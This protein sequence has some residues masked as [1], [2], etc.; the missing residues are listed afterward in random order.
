ME[1]EHVQT[2]I[3]KFVKS[4]WEFEITGWKTPAP[5]ANVLAN[6][7]GYGVL[8]TADSVCYSWH[9]DSKKR[10]INRWV[11]DFS[12]A[13]TGR[14]F[15]IGFNDTLVSIPW[16][17]VCFNWESYKCFHA[18]G[19]TRWEACAGPLSVTVTVFVPVNVDA[20]IWLWEFSSEIPLDI[21]FTS[22]CELLLG[23]EWETHREFY[24]LRARSSLN[25]DIL[26]ISRENFEVFF[27]QSMAKK[28]TSDL[29][30]FM[31]RAGS[32]RCP[33]GAFKG[34]FGNLIDPAAAIRS[35]FRVNEPVKIVFSMGVTPDVKFTPEDAERLFEETKNFWRRLM[36]VSWVDTPDENFNILVNIWCKYQAA[37]SRLWGRTGWYQASGAYGFRDQLQDSLAFLYMDPNVTKKQILLHAKHQFSDGRVLHWWS[38]ADEKGVDLDF[39]DDFLWLAYAISEYIKHTGDFYILGEEVPFLDKKEGTIWDHFMASIKRAARRVGPNGLP[40]MGGGDWNDGLSNMENGESTWLAMFYLFV[41]RNSWFL[42]KRALTRVKNNIKKALERL[43]AGINFAWDGEKFRRVYRDGKWVEGDRLFLNT[44]SWAVFC[45]K[46]VA[47]SVA[48]ILKLETPYGLLLFTPA[49]KEPDDS[50]GYIT[51]YSPGTR[52]NGGVYTHAALWGVLA[53]CE[54]GRGDDAW[55]ILKKLSPIHSGFD[56]LYMAEPYAIAANRDGPE[57]PTPGRAS[58]TWYTGSAA[59]FLRVAWEG[60]LGVK[61]TEHDIV[62]SPCLPSEWPG[63]EAHR[64]FKGEVRKIIWRNR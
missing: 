53:L 33:S 5:W 52:E 62:L 51:Y 22:F 26:K 42:I 37:A 36:E 10:R 61:V 54:A 24:K 46:K 20:E 64:F 15:Y 6:P 57:S 25:G 56:P 58:W 43:E 2:V 28:F 39:G 23:P 63:F 17:P 12:G 7:S 35:E 34:V 47:A 32:F 3:G 27:Y 60:I 45:G 38:P 16:R 49:F 18:P 13:H 29:V 19:Y 48:N 21:S 50:I 8:V 30:D 55:R 1:R 9:L 41:I 31:G 40:Y 14:G 4:G 59:W 11:Q 44:H